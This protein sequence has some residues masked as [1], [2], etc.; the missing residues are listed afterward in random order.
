MSALHD[1]L[2]IIL[3][4]LAAGQTEVAAPAPALHGTIAAMQALGARVRPAH[5]ATVFDGVGN[6]C[7][8][9]PI[10]TLAFEDPVPSFLVAGLVA[11]YDMATRIACASAFPATDLSAFLSATAAMGIQG[12]APD[13]ATISLQGQP[14][15]APTAHDAADW[16]EAVTVAV[17]LAALNTPGITR[18]EGA[19]DAPRDLIDL[20][21]RFGV[22]CELSDTR[23][24]W[25]FAVTGQGNVR[26]LE[27]GSIP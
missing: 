17:A 8:L 14:S 20:L 7:L 11:P 6:G 10:G 4:G 1:H 19:G 5:D 23:G 24:R 22:Q 2:T 18:L 9:Q 21:T 12:S 26:A 3:A 27:E 25:S 16:S 13:Q 15:P